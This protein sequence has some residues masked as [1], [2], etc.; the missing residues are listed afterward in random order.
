GAA[1]D[2]RFGGEAAGEE[3]LADALAGHHVGGHRR[4]TREQDALASERGGVDARRD[5]PRRMT[6]L[7]DGGGTEGGAEVRAVEQAGPEVLHVLDPP[8]AVAQHAEADVGPPA[9][10]RERPRV[11][12]E[13]VGVEPHEEVATGR[14]VDAPGVLAEGVPLA[15]VAL[16]AG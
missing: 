5:R 16:R 4:V 15:E 9:G 10:Q 14:A 6:A 3:R 12:R 13:E 1:G 8:P 2:D 11:P 7:E